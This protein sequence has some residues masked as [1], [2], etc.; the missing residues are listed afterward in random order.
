MC[1]LVHPPP[2]IPQS[3]SVS[4]PPAHDYVVCYGKVPRFVQG[5]LARDGEGGYLVVALHYRKDVRV[6]L[7]NELISI[8]VGV[9]D[10]EEDR[11]P[12]VNEWFT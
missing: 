2:L 1:L 5:G 3:S 12:G 10:L 4:A 8:G 11:H 7:A 6:E 9:W